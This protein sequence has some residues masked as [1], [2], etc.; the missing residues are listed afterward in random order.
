MV[1]EQYDDNYGGHEEGEYHFSDEPVSYDVEGD[2]PEEAPKPAK[3][4]AAASSG[5]EGEAKPK[6]SRRTLIG[7]V[8]F[9]ILLFVV[10]KMLMPSTPNPS[11]DF[12][13]QK[14][15]VNKPVPAAPLPISGAPKPSTPTQ[16]PTGFDM[17]SAA[18]Q[19]GA[20]VVSVGGGSSLGASLAETK[21][22][23]DKLAALERQNATAL[24]QLQTQRSQKSDENEARMTDMRSKIQELD[25]HISNIETKINQLAQLIT[26]TNKPS[27]PP[28][29]QSTE[30]SSSAEEQQPVSSSPPPPIKSAQPKLSYT[31][32]AIIPGRAWLK[33]DA[34]DTVTVAEGDVLKDYGRI[35]KIDPYDGVVE[36][37][38]GKKVITLSYGVS[39]N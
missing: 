29:S 37:D 39:G 22:M 12:S 20:A 34:G 31:V 18:S 4:A 6:P 7:G 35:T 25:S 19:P 27:A 11:M 33:S 17:P 28:K 38:T 9:F 32:Q 36:I 16:Q 21:S 23:V 10:Y 15:V 2:T 13:Q 26:S 14:A 5:K 24:D 8:I 30:S 1:D 3:A